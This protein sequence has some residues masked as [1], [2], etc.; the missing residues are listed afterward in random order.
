MGDHTICLEMDFV[1]VGGGLTGVCAALA[2][3]RHGMRVA[4]CHDRSVLGG[5]SSS[6]CR[7]WICG[8]T[9]MGFNRYAD[10]TGIIAELTQ[11]NLY[12]NPEGNPHLWDALLLDKV[13]EEKNIT[14]LLEARVTEVRAEGGRIRSAVCEQFCSETRYVLRAGLFADCTGDAVLTELAG[15]GTVCGNADVSAAAR[16]RYNLSA[17]YASLGS[18]LLFYTRRCGHPVRFVPPAFAYSVEE[19]ARILRRTGKQ[20]HAGDSGCDYWW[21]EYGGDMDVIHDNEAIRTALTRLIYGIW[22]YIKNS[23]EFDAGCLTLEWV[24]SIPARRECRRALAMR[25]LTEEDILARPRPDDAVCH[26]GWPVDTHPSSGFFDKSESC[27]QLPVDPYGIPLSCLISRDFEN[28][29]IAGRNAGMNHLAMASARVMKTCAVEGQAIGTAA[30]FARRW[31]AAPRALLPEQIRALQAQLTRDDVWIPGQ[32]LDP[33]RDAARRMRV[34]SSAPLAPDAGE[35]VRFLPVNE[36]AFLL[37]PPLQ[38]GDRIALSLRAASAGSI[39]IGL[40]ESG[41]PAVYKP[42]GL[43]RTFDFALAPGERRVEL[44]CPAGTRGNCCI[45]IPASEGVEIGVAREPLPGVLGVFAEN[46]LGLELFAPA[47]RIAPVAA[48]YPTEALT[49]GY[50]R[51]YG[52][53]HLWASPLEGA[54]IALE[55]DVPV[56]AEELVLYLDN[57]LYLPHNNLRPERDPM[58]NRQI[59]PP[60]MRDFTVRLD[61]PDGAREVCVRENAQRCVRLP[62]GGA[63]V[64]RVRIEPHANWGASYVAV[65]E[66]ALFSSADEWAEV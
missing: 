9:G 64:S 48:W 7:V 39:Q 66:I 18:T 42:R 32:S 1:V 25:T 10:E 43:L 11:E 21:L 20:L 13:W 23:G 5:N 56:P 58:W 47:V 16:A 6:E 52:G 24:G 35:P 26:G 62:L 22:N 45:R 8:A 33:A 54:W 14:L 3:A 53:M 27:Q 63:P 38:K 4:L 50:T 55:S 17:Q 28:V 15:G 30:A 31:N 40:Y 2:A 34:S 51:P 46:A 41:D 19:I 29:L 12:R 37:L 59:H 65:Y 36:A 57:A 44:D 61:G 60:L 49:D